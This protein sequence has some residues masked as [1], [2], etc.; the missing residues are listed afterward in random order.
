MPVVNKVRNLDQ[1]LTGGT[2]LPE[3]QLKKVLQLRDFLDK[4]C[5]LDPAKRISLNQ[6]LTHPFIQTT[7]M[8]TE[9]PLSSATA[10]SPGG[11]FQLTRS[12]APPL[13]NSSCSVHF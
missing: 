10:G 6:C 2:K 8:K 5:V 1:E 9:D 3:D 4:I 12:S 7:E 11:A 13:G